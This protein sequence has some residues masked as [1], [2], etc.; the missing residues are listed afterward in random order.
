[1]ILLE[2]LRCFF[3]RAI[4]SGGNLSFSNSSAIASSSSNSLAVFSLGVFLDGILPSCISSNRFS[5]RLIA[6]SVFFACEAVFLALR[7]CFGSTLTVRFDPAILTL[8]SA[9]L[10][11]LTVFNLETLAATLPTS[12]LSNKWESK[13]DLACKTASALGSAA[14][15]WACKSLPE[16]ADFLSLSSTDVPPLGWSF[17]LIYL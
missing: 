10:L 8:N 6:A 1:M 12:A 2:S 4:C 11:S 3:L 7:D 5:K 15:L 14:F 17:N 16:A 9:S 13:S